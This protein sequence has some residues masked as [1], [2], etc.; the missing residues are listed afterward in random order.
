MLFYPLLLLW[1]PHPPNRVTAGSARASYR[2]L[3]PT[4]RIVEAVLISGGWTKRAQMSP[5]S[6]LCLFAF[7]VCGRSKDCCR[8]VRRAAHMT[9][10]MLEKM[11]ACVGV[12]VP[13]LSSFT[14][15]CLFLWRLKVFRP[16]VNLTFLIILLPH[17]SDSLYCNKPLWV[18]ISKKDLSQIMLL[19][20]P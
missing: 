16:H 12:Y 9:W 1:P 18:A 11:W 14:N 2:G 15:I 6:G 19:R 7:S 5:Q 4:L 13:Q 8:H 10:H 20:V 3:P 17:T